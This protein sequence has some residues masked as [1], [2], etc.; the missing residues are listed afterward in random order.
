VLQVPV[1]DFVFGIAALVGG[2]LLLINILLDDVLGGVFDALGLG[3]DV[4]GT[5]ITP[6]LLAF[7]AMFGAGGLFAT[8]A[9]DVHGA[10]AAGVGAAFGIAG[11]AIAGLLFSVL[12][13]S[14]SPEPFSL[15]DLVGETGYVS[16]A[17]PGGRQGTVLVKAEG[18]THEFSA[19]ATSD[20]PAGTTVRIVGVAGAGLIVALE[21]TSQST[22]PTA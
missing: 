9:L 22:Q 8:Q 19:T 2:V 4:G 7:V 16:V 21:E 14:E 10:Q 20:V 1:E 17:I 13:R 5:S 15:G 12:R 11:A 18:Q 3:F 6:L